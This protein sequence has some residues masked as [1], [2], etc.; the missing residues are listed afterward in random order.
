MKK[1]EI[2]IKAEKLEELKEELNKFGIQ[3]MM[4]TNIMGF[5]NQKG[6]TQ[7]YRGTEIKVNLLPKIK[8]EVIIAAENVDDI[9]KKVC[10]VVSTGNIG[11]GKIFVYDVE[12]AVRIRTRER[13]VS[14]I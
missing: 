9:I 5:G 4:I 10:E 6:T 12:D 13:G 3:G 1:L 7:Y 8:V 11:D 14:A 2:V